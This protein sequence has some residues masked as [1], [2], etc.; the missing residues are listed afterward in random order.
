MSRKVQELQALIDC[1]QVFILMSF[2][3]QIRFMFSDVSCIEI[4]R[5]NIS[6]AV[7]PMIQEK[8]VENSE[9]LWS[10]TFDLRAD[11]DV[12]MFIFAHTFSSQT[13]NRN[14]NDK[15]NKERKQQQLQI[16]CLEEIHNLKSSFTAMHRHIKWKLEKLHARLERSQECFTADEFT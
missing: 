14:F 12:L 10:F 4:Q 5:K 13:H 3:L 9:E 2:P 7:I 6:L 16:A 11:Y 15:K 8:W 1:F